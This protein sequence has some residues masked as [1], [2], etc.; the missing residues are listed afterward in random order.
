[1]S[2]QYEHNRART[3]LVL[4]P[5]GVK[6]PLSPGNVYNLEYGKN[7]PLGYGTERGRVG[8][9]V[10]GIV[11]VGGSVYDSRGGTDHPEFFILVAYR[12]IMKNRILPLVA[13]THIFQK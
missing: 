2:G 13:T 10:P 5:V 3:N 6:D 12:K 4:A 8:L 7:T 1:M 11:H 9:P